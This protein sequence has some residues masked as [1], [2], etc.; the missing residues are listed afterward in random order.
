[1]S[2]TL[3]ELRAVVKIAIFTI[4]CFSDHMDLD[5]DSQVGFNVDEAL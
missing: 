2:A 4:G 5:D 3:Q 1:M